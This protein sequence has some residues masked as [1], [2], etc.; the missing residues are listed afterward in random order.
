MPKLMIDG[1]EIEVAPGKTILQAAREIAV[2]VPTFCYYEKLAISGSCRMCTVELEG[3]NKLAIACAT[4]AKDGMVVKTNTAK[5]KAARAA[6]MEFLLINHPL[7][8]PVCDRCGDCELQ[9]LSFEYGRD[10]GRYHDHKRTYEKFPVGEKLEL[11]MNRC[12]HCRRCTRYAQDVIK[13]DSWGVFERSADSRMGP[14]APGV[15]LDTE[16]DFLGNLI[17]V[18][19]TGAITDKPFRFKERAWNLEAREAK[20]SACAHGCQTWVWVSVLDGQVKRV[21]ARRNP[22]GEVTAFICDDCRYQH[23]NLQD[24]EFEA[25]SAFQW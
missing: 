2:D 4:E 22:F 11:E 1:A 19:P 21:T 9:D 24:W 20:R 25:P 3:Q 6:D 8:C 14:Y 5:V 12:I 13:I 23:L 10:R 15:N 17:D 7:D 18:C 16:S